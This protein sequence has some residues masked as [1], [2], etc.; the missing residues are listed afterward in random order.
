MEE[1]KS[2][3]ITMD[4][5]KTSIINAIKTLR[6]HKKRPDELT[7]LE[8]AKKG[9]QTTITINNINVNLARLTEIGKIKNKPSN[10][11]NSYYLINDSTDATD[12]QPPILTITNTPIV[13][14][15]VNVDNSLNSVPDQIDSFISSDTEPDATEFSD[16]SDVIDNAYKN[17]KYQKIKDILL[18]DIKKD[19]CDFIQN[20]I[21]QKINLYSQDEHQ[22]LVDKRIIANLEK[23]IHFLKTEIETKNEIIKNFIKNDSHRDEN[24]NVPQDGQFWEFTR[25]SSDSD[26]NE[27]NTVN[28][29]IDE[30]LKAIRE[31]KHKE[32]L[33]NTSRK[34][35]SQENIVIETNEM[36]DRDKTNEQPNDTHDKNE[37]KNEQ[38]E[39]NNQ[40]CWP[41]EH[42][43]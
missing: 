5:L 11:R 35:P 43:H 9:L 8:F 21:R 1:L 39:R 37:V 13:E 14:K 38:D 18:K 31:E 33:Q 22:T 25:M 17:I 4:T 30:Q 40:F 24:Y 36:N 28:R 3:S 2:N 26:T 19:V 20:E 10:N 29:N 27:I 41:Q 7:V 34:S 15:N 32:Y 23:E 16:T 6:S 12:S 42:S